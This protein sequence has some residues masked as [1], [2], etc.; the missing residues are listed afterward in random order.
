MGSTLP[1]TE[2]KPRALDRAERSPSLLA[3]APS[4]EPI[5]M[6]NMV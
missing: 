3:M 5:G 6:L 1:I 4:S 2:P